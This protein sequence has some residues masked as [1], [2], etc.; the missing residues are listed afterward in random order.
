[1]HDLGRRGKS[2]NP[3]LKAPWDGFHAAGVATLLLFL[4]FPAEHR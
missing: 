1:M 3:G 2:H 4:V